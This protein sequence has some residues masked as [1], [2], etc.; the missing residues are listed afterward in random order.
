MR[1]NVSSMRSNVNPGKNVPVN[2]GQEEEL[3]LLL[4]RFRKSG[5]QARGA[6]MRLST[7][8]LLLRKGVIDGVGR[9]VRAMYEQESIEPLPDSLAQLVARLNASR[10]SDAPRKVGQSNTG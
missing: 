2:L 4:S 5:G 6:A 1:S 9:V 3:D 7:E 10:S 8:R